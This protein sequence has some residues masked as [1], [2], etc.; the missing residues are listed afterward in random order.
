MRNLNVRNLSLVT[1]ALL[2]L[3]ACQS[4]KD[5]PI[6]QKTVQTVKADKS[7]KNKVFVSNYDFATTVAKIEA[8]VKEKGM[9]VFAIIDHQEAAKQ[10]GLTMQPAK[11][12]VFGTPKAGTPLMV[13]DPHFAL[14]LPL[15]VLVT[16]QNGKVEVVMTDTHSLI[17]GSK[18][19]YTEVENSL[20]KAVGLIENLVK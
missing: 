9:T 15:K 19:T 7:M 11:V 14:E 3:T 12:I 20:A 10:A 1:I 8:G 16:K 2:S 13:K 17:D 6:V 5:T 4:I 18:I